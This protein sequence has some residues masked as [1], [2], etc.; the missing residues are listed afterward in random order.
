MTTDGKIKKPLRA[1]GPLL[2]DASLVINGGCKVAGG[3]QV[4][5]AL[6]KK[7]MIVEALDSASVLAEWATALLLTAQRL[8]RTIRERVDVRRPKNS[9]RQSE[10]RR[11]SD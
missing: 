11:I 3:A 9:T 7:R 4:V 1:Y 8:Q 10:S 6:L 2:K 5:D